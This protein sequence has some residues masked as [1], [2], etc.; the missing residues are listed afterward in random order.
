MQRK[1]ENAKFKY[2]IRDIYRE[3]RVSSSIIICT[4]LHFFFFDDAD[5]RETFSRLL[6]IRRAII[7][8]FRLADLCPQN[9]HFE[10]FRS[11]S[12]INCATV[13]PLSSARKYP[14]E[15]LQRARKYA[16]H[17]NNNSIGRR[18]LRINEPCLSGG[19]HYAQPNYRPMISW[20][21]IRN[22]IDEM[23]GRLAIHRRIKRPRCPLGR[24]AFAYL[25][26]RTCELCP[27]H[28]QRLRVCV[29]HIFS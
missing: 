1:F 14:R 29:L 6:I 11:L 26:P 8:T 4:L 24:R 22:P 23:S 10:K 16:N 12:H 28:G 19:R 18:L 27:K 3:R 5:G 20:N 13:S 9:S 21:A 17:F 7:Q 25:M 15:C 2:A